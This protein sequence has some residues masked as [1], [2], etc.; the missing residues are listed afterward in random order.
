MR[1]LVKHYRERASECF[2]LAR[3]T[4]DPWVKRSLESLGYEMLEEA[5]EIEQS[6]TVMPDR[7][8]ARRD[9]PDGHT[10]A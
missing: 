5:D 8:P 1:Q 4:D 2:R 9:K 3:D 7:L 6:P 10:G